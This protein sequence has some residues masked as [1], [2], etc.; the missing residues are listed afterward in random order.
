MKFYTV[1]IVFL[2]TIAQANAQEYKVAK[3]TGKLTII[4]VNDVRIEGYDGKEIVFTSRN[5]SDE[6]DDRANGLRAISS[7][8]LE[9]NTGI[10]LAVQTNGDVVEVR[11]LKKMDGPEIL[12]KVP[13]GIVISYEH[14]SPYG[15]EFRLKNLE[16]EVQIS[17]VHN[18][19][20]LENVTGIV[21]VKTV[22]GDIDATFPTIKNKINLESVHGH[23]DIALPADTKANLKMSTSWGEIF[24]DP[25]LKI[26]MEKKDGLQNYSDKFNGKLNGGGL[27]IEL[28]STHNNV[29]LR[30]K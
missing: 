25:G 10:G 26:E 30:K 12:I 29:Y 19:V 17:T 21:N 5:H 27:E 6:R 1:L 15:D 14:S 16:N 8:G 20:M 13:K 2:L 18:Q 11:Q 7:M 28:A 9:D 3:A 23:V 4:E 22:H 24:V